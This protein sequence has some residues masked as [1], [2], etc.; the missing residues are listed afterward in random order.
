MELIFPDLKTGDETEWASNVLDQFLLY[1]H[2]IDRIFQ[3]LSQ[4]SGQETYDGQLFAIVY[5]LLD[6]ITVQWILPLLTKEAIF[7]HRPEPVIHAAPTRSSIDK[8]CLHKAIEAIYN[9]T[10]KNNGIAPL[11]LQRSLPDLVAGVCELGFNP[12][13]ARPTNSRFEGC[14][15]KLIDR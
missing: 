13:H 10:I 5:G 1:L 9:I 4:H 8:R 14:Y 3:Q 7:I 6:T 12:A 2:Q 11:I 15:T